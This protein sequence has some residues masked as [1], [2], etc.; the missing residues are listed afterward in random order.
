MGV[1]VR[2]VLIYNIGLFYV[3]SK[4][5]CILINEIFSRN[6]TIKMFNGI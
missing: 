3:I 1:D 5:Y 6:N 2:A 4:I